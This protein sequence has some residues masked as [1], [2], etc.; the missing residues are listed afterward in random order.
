[1]SKHD[2]IVEI[3]MAN[4]EHFAKAVRLALAASSADG[5]GEM[6][7]EWLH[8]LAKD[9]PKLWAAWKDNDHPDGPAVA[10]ITGNGETSEANA[11][12][13]ASARK[14]VLGLVSEVDR[15]R[16]ILRNRESPR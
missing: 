5:W 9:S 1:M 2:P 6:K 16:T 12:F 8:A 3:D 7:T 15:L 14:I 13:F 11:E 10:A 4:P